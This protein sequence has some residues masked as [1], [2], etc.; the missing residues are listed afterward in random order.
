MKY[1]ICDYR[2]SEFEELKLYELG[3]KVIKCPKC[4]TLYDA[5]CGHPDMLLHLLDGNRIIVHK[6]M[7]KEFTDKLKG[8]K[9]KILYSTEN[10][11]SEYPQDI[12]LN[13]LSLKDMFIH[14]LKYTDKEL[15]NNVSHKNLID[16]TQGYTKC[17]VAVINENSVITSDK[18]I[19]DELIKRDI[20]VLLLP[21]GDIELPNLN[22]GFIGGT[23]GLLNENIITFYGN[24]KFYKYGKE[25]LNFL[26]KKGVKPLYLNDG[27]LIDRGSIFCLEI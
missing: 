18:I 5:V 9:F 16:V 15:L 2:I 20:D 8:L 10:I 26:K 22:Y 4:N 1:V 25:V 21:P 6:A 12:I 17:S 24:L 27:K 14:N 7:P 3:Y 11:K 23:C 13:G 19:A